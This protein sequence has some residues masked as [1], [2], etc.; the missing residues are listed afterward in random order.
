MDD[1]KNNGPG[2][3][4][5]REGKLRREGSPIN[6]MKVMP[7]KSNLLSFSLEHSS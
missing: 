3:I 7:G 1:L 5:G 4:K 2:M 6:A